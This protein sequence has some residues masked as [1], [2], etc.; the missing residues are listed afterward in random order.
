MPNEEFLEKRKFIR[1]LISIPLKYA[2]MSIK[3]LNDVVTSDISAEG[4]GLITAE[5]LPLNT[6]LN[7]CLVMPDNGEEI[8]LDAEALWSKSKGTGRYRYGLKL[9]DT[10]LKPI[11]LVLRTIN[12][13]F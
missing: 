13:R 5:E 2:K 10:Q 8:T 1:F 4:L 11:P 6:P 7:I 9:K 12:S 3:Q